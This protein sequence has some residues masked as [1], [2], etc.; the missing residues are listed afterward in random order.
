M[1]KEQNPTTFSILFRMMLRTLKKNVAQFLSIIAIGAIAVTLFTGLISNADV[2]ETQVDNVFQKGNLADLWVTTQK[3]DSEDEANVASFLHE[4]EEIEGRFYLPVKGLS[5]S[6]YLAVV[7]DIPK[8]SAP[9]DSKIDPNIKDFVYV[10]RSIKEEIDSKFYEGGPISFSLDISSYR[11][12]SLKNMVSML[13]VFLKDGGKNI[14]NQ[15]KIDL[16]MTITGFMDYPENINK[17]AYQSSVV[18]ISDSAFRKSILSLFED[19]FQPQYINIIYTAIASYLGFNSLDSEYITNPNQYLIKASSERD[20][21]A[22]SQQIRDYYSSKENNNLYY[23]TK[24]SQMPFYITVYNDVRQ[25]RQFTFVFPMVFFLVAVL[26]ILTTLSQLVLKDR[27]Q[28]GTLKAIGVGK[29][30]IYGF[31]ISLTCALVFLSTLIGEIV[32][33]LLIPSI[34]GNKYGIIYT[35][36]QRQYQFPVLYGLL[37]ALAFLLFSGFVTFLV[38]HKEVSLKPCE[39]MRPKVVEMKKAGRKIN[40][41]EKT[42]FFS[43]KMAMRNIFMNKAKSL[44]VI[45]GVMGCTALLVCGYGIEDT[46][47]Y[48]INQDIEHFRGEDITLNFNA[49][50]SKKQLEEDLYSVQGVSYFESSINATCTAYLDDGPREDTTFYIIPDESRLKKVSFSVDGI[51]I[52]EKISRKLD[53]RIGDEI[54]FLYNNVEYKGKVDTIFEAF[55]YNGIMVH[56]G[57]PIFKDK[58]EFLYQSAAVDISEDADLTRVREELL[59]LSYVSDAKTQAEWEE[60]IKSVMSG[61]LVMTNAVK[62]FAVLLGIVVLYNL[63]LMNFKERS[64]DIATLKVLGFNRFEILRSLMIESMSLTAIGVL[65][66]LALGYPFMLAVLMTN[67][68]ELVE[69]IY[70]IKALSYFL[71]FLLT[72]GVAAV[73]NL[74]LTNRSKKIQMVESLKSVE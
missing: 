4:D 5:H 30:H 3:Y 69:Y 44:M 27:N 72:F 42:G 56:E 19:N 41:D 12:E 38:C 35:L 26:V 74:I 23:V 58:G 40:P 68:V 60:R 37:T 34:L 70:F 45:I 7:R 49:S 11:T 73:I 22:L 36:P 6:F 31:Y 13:D 18:L 16:N 65:F 71:S 15:D 67:I 64:R 43:F 10:D 62:I 20:I 47:Y 51:A 28:I 17:A 24:R 52:S 32:G 63:S 9:Y 54:S 50:I 33:P 55:F 53:C 2:F 48:G 66:G 25:A 21:D 29:A 59:K 39:S 1:V 8:I 14:F 46:V 61:I 57:N